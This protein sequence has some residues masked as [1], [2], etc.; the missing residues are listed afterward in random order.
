MGQ[1]GSSSGCVIMMDYLPV[2]LVATL[3]GSGLADPDPSL[4][5][6][7]KAFTS[8]VHPSSS[9]P[10]PSYNAP[11]TSYKPAS[12]YS[13]PAPAYG[14]PPED[15]CYIKPSFNKEPSGLLLEVQ[16][17]LNIT[18]TPDPCLD[19]PFNGNGTWSIE[20]LGPRPEEYD[21]RLDGPPKITAP[22]RNVEGEAHSYQ[23]TDANKKPYLI[24]LK[25]N[26]LIEESFTPDEEEPYGSH[27]HHERTK[28]QARGRGRRGAN[29]G[30]NTLTAEGAIDGINLGRSGSVGQSQLG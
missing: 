16:Q 21:E 7:N 13:N 12:A 2:L 19:G 29:R 15:K 5:A 3:V 18:F 8:F 4:A 1:S 25:V 14:A 6:V 28:R 30:K 20:Y 10:Q 27:G 23:Y 11:S 24:M 26:K 9:R 22:S 17:L